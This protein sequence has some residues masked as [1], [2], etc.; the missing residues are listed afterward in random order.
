MGIHPQVGPYWLADICPFGEVT[1]ATAWQGGLDTFS[2]AIPTR[3]TF[4][5]LRRGASVVIRDGGLSLGRGII[6]EVGDGMVHGKGLAQLAY[7]APSLNAANAP[8]TWPDDSIDQA[9]AR[10]DVPGWSRPVSI[11]GGGGVASAS[12][13]TA[14]SLGALLDAYATS[15]SSAWW[16]DQDGA[17]R[18]RGMAASPIWQTTPANGALTTASDEYVTHLVATYMNGASTVDSRRYPATATTLASDTWGKKTA[19]VDLT[20]IGV[21]STTT[22]DNILAGMLAKG[23]ARP[24][25]ADPLDVTA[26]DLTTGGGVRGYL[27]AVAGGDGVR[28]HGTFDDTRLLGGYLFTDITAGRVEYVDGAE[29][30]RITPVGYTARDFKSILTVALE[31]GEAA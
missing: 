22:V 12:A 11:Y 21:L 25:Y 17:V 16:I 3:G 30:A 2:W 14:I 27:P 6:T 28:L 29:T 19:Q 23:M 7:D 5:V 31:G 9:I 13:D 26:D 20:P 4:P 24:T 18:I 1:W 15:I 10:G 8:T